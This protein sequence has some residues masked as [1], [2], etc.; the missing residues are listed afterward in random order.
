VSNITA[1]AQQTVTST[2]QG[3]KGITGDEK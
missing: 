2:T 1:T 3:G